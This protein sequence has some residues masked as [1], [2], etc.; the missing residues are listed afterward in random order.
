[1]IIDT[2]A[3]VAIARE[4]AGRDQLR[5]A[6]LDDPG[7]IPAPVVIEFHRVT[8]GAGNVPDEDAIMLLDQLIGA[9]CSIEPFTAADAATAAVANG[10]FGTGN[11][12]GGRLN[13]LDLIVYAMAR[14]TLRPVLCTGRDFATTDVGIH[15]ASRSF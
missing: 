1:M 11:G 8:A 9:G 2:S 15:P 14:R 4:E 6:I 10:N 13:M 3:L 5:D 12:R 7:L